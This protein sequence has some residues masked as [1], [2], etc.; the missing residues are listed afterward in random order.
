L[1][2]KARRPAL[3]RALSQTATLPRVRRFRKLCS[4]L[5][6]TLWL[7]ASSHS[8]L[9]T[10]GLIH[11]GDQQAH[12]TAPASEDDHDHDAAD[13]K[14]AITFLKVSVPKAP[15]CLFT[16]AFAFCCADLTD[17][18]DQ[19]INP[20]GLAPPEPFAIPISSWQFSLRTALAPRAPSLLS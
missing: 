10:S 2:R 5:L 1:I 4:F 3:L 16:F 20:S 15:V 6:A 19:Q 18:L 17:D 12:H 11:K 9:E 8:L 14:C 13:G 7:V